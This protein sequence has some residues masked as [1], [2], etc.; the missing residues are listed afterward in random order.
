MKRRSIV[1]YVLELIVI[2]GFLTLGVT[3]L[4]YLFQKVAFDKIII[5]AIILSIG[6]LELTDFITWK[7]A[8]RVR[9]IQ[10]L[11]AA[12]AGIALGIVILVV[13]NMDENTMCILWGAFS[14]AFSVAKI[15]TGTINLVY[16]PL[17]N[18]VKIILAITE[19]VFSILLIVEKAGAIHAHM[20]FLSVALIVEAFTLVI[21][22]IIHRYQR[23]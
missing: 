19:I 1:H 5:G 23:L 16:Q 9:S 21:E 11:I 8:T 13:K 15:A 7:Y 12:L 4:T 6:V 17:L 2:V 20:V 22:F 14:I 3:V 18:I 10:S